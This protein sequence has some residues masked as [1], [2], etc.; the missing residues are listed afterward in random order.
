[1]T[2]KGNRKKN[3]RVREKLCI[4]I[5]VKSHSKT[6]AYGF[7]PLIMNIWP[8]THPIAYGPCFALFKS[9]SFYRGTNSDWNEKGLHPTWGV[10]HYYTWWMKALPTTEYRTALWEFEAWT[11]GSLWCHILW[12]SWVEVVVKNGVCVPGVVVESQ[13]QQHTVHVLSVGE[14]NEGGDTLTHILNFRE[15]FL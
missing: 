4:F 3:T 1:M 6:S 14:W 11:A 5:H 9:F 2:D 8:R 13:C 15:S 12:T 10:T 7:F